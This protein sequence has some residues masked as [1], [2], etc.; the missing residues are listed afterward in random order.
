MDTEDDRQNRRAF[1]GKFGKSAAFLPSLSYILMSSKTS[2]ANSQ[3]KASD[4]VHSQE[5]YDEIVRMTHE[6]MRE[7]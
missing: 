4:G 6:K 2:S 3:L 5:F 7:T 1:L